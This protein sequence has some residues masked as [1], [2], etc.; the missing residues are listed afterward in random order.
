MAVNVNEEKKAPND[1]YHKSLVALTGLG[2]HCLSLALSI[3]DLSRIEIIRHI[4]KK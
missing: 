4:Q 1:P 3:G 2:P